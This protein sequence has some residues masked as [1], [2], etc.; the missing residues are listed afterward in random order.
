MSLMKNALKGL[1]VAAAL[2]ATGVTAQAQEVTLKLHQF[3]P[4]QANVPKFVIDPWIERVQEASGGKIKIDHYPSMQLGGT[5]P[6]LI[7]QVQDGV[8]DITWT[9]LGYTPS[10]F[11]QAEVFELPFMMNNAEATSRAFWEFAE[12]NMFDTDL[13]DFKVL[14]VWVHGPGLIHSKSPITTVSDLN[15]VKLRAPTRIINK[16][17][18]DLGATPVGM[19]VP[20]IPEALSKGVID[21]AVIPWEVT[22]ALKVPELVQNHTEFGNES[23]YTTAFVFAMNK[24]KYESLSDEMKAA[25]DSQS[26]ADFSALAGKTQGEGDAPARKLAV[27]AGNNIITLTDEQV[28]EWKAAASNVEA[29]WVEDMNGKGFDG[30]A[31]LDQAK[32][33]IKKN[34]M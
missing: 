6:D 8:A 3:L 9:V 21:A 27:E 17:V 7:G 2:T 12:A 4:A 34:G 30:Q 16:M 14:G 19:P 20:A 22:S 32:E 31:L 10:R 18:S 29:G 33:L 28:A 23:L 5:P 1:A 15:G 24:Q 11:P 13:K 25:L 26:G